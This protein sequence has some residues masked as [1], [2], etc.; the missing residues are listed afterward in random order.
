MKAAAENGIKT[1][2]Y[3]YSTA[4]ST[5]QAKSD[6]QWVIDQLQGYNISYPVA[7]DMEDNSQISLGKQAITNMVKVFCNEIESAG[8]TPMIYCNE[9]WAKNYIDFS[10]LDGIYKWIARYNG[11]YNENIK[12]DIWQAG[13]TTLLEGITVNSVDIDFGYTD[14]TTIVTPRTEHLDT[15]VKH[16]GM[17]VLGT[18]GWWYDNGDGTYPASQWF[19]DEMKYYYFNSQGYLQTGW[20]KDNGYWYY[21]TE[22]GILEKTWLQ[23]NGTWYYFNSD[24][25]MI[26][27]WMKIKDKWY[28]FDASGAMAA[29]TT[30]DGYKLNA[31]GEWEE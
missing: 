19:F 9:N 24:G 31:N 20:I 27:G 30:I 6:A 21:S 15:Y 29:N 16:I 26:T 13:S 17:W 7:L 22:Y 5:S 25:V 18:G 14:F 4:T 12:R 23:Y 28:Y 11:T 8:Y 3:F 10:Q 1:G 2:V